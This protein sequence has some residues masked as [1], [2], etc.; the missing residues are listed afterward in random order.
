M[1]ILLTNDDGI[2]AH[3]IQI[4]REVLKQKGHEIFIVAPLFERSAAS[5]SLTIREPLRIK[6]YDDRAWAVTGT[7]VDCVIMAFEHILKEFEPV[8]L[9]ISGI[10]AGQNLGDDV[11]YSGT[12]GAAIEA[13]CIGYKA[14]AVSTTSYK[15]QNYHTAAEVLALLIDKGMTEMI[16]SREIVNINVPNID[17]QDIQ[18][19]KITRTGYRRYQN[20]L[21]HQKDH[22]QNDIF[23][24]GGEDPIWEFYH[25]DIDGKVIDDNY[26]SISPLKIDFSNDELRGRFENWLVHKLPVR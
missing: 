26:V 5:H 10:N 11:L 17:L 8:D 3:G 16:G 22:R 4:L 1:R 19:Y 24:I 21:H 6:R 7:P 15:N 20:I 25:E 18:G 23:W 12:V 13:M 14:I 2:E 9:V